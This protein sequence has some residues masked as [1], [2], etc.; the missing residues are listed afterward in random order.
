MVGRN[1]GRNKIEGKQINS[2]L[3]YRCLVKNELIKLSLYFIARGLYAKFKGEQLPPGC[4]FDFTREE[5]LNFQNFLEKMKKDGFNPHYYSLGNDVF[6]CIVVFDEQKS[7]LSRMWL[8]FYE[9]V[10]FRIITMP[11][12]YDVKKFY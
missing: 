12:D 9:S 10:F 7:F 11:S 3:C 8:S 6:S 5:K 1:F 2:Q 4:K